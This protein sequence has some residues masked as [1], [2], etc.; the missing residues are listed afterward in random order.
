MSKHTIA[1][2]EDDESIRL[3]LLELLEEKGFAVVTSEN[4]RDALTLLR[5][6]EGPCIVIV[7]LETPEIGGSE[8]LTAKRADPALRNFPVIILSAWTH[9]LPPKTEPNE[10]FIR[11]PIGISALVELVGR[12]CS[13]ETRRERER[14][15]S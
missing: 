13:D 4:G 9:R 12:Y 10:H 6:V 14:K 5:R 2:L 7:D 1:L 11:K 3:S 15:V 8:F